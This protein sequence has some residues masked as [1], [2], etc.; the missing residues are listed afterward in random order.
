[1]GYRG[2]EGPPASA[3]LPASKGYRESV[4]PPPNAGIPVKREKLGIWGCQVFAAL[5]APPDC[6]P[7]PVS[8]ALRAHP[9]L[10]VL[11]VLMALRD[12]LGKKAPPDLL[13]PPD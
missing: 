2:S 1:M 8:P 7:S 5:R 3:G 10:R 9:A 6:R 11:R 4:G 12:P 13:E